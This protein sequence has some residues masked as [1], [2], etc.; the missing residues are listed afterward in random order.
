MRDGCGLPR[1]YWSSGNRAPARKYARW[2]SRISSGMSTLS[3]S[4]TWFISDSRPVRSKRYEPVAPSASNGPCRRVLRRSVII[5]RFRILSF[6]R[7]KGRLRVPQPSSSD[8]RLAQCP[9][10]HRPPLDR[11]SQAELFKPYLSSV[12]PVY[13]FSGTLSAPFDP[14]DALPQAIRDQS[15]SWP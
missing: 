8:G 4:Y 3:T 7:T 6:W 15:R 10:S 11:W 2:I 5:A 12:N 1:R 13:V 9:G 14:F